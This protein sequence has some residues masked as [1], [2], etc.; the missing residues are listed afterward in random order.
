MEHN[1]LNKMDL[2]NVVKKIISLPVEFEKGDDSIYSLLKNTGYF[3]VYDRVT[4]NVISVELNTCLECIENWLCW[5]ENKRTDEGWYF[6]KMGENKYIV[7]DVN[8]NSK[9]NES[10]EIEDAKK[11]CSIFIKREIESIRLS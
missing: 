4:E 9:K 1:W 3:S 2:M 6:L 11:A 7:G 10:F 8:S 5:S